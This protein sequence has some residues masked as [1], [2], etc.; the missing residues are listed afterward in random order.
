M[1]TAHLRT[2]ALAVG[3]ACLVGGPAFADAVPT[4]TPVELAPIEHGD[5]ML[6]VVAAD[7]SVTTYSASELESLPT[8][9]IETTTPWEPEPL[10]F[11]GIMLADLLARHDLAGVDIEVLAEDEFV[12]RIEAEVSATGDFMIA[13]R[14]DGAPLT[15]AYR[16]PLLFV[17]PSTSLGED[18][19]IRERH[20]VWMAA[21]IRPVG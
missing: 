3:L 21:Q 4:F 18:S 16:G 17:V 8:W 15:R 11:E 9:A 5:G 19:V 10:R 12:S 20:L 14:V 13:T 7:G 2:A 1:L 6:R